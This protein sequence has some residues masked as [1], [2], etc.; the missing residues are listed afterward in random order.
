MARDCRQ[1]L[2]IIRGNAR[3]PQVDPQHRIRSTV[4]EG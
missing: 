3:Q 4:G 1:G 2:V